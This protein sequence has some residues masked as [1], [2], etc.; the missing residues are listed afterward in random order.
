MIRVS[1]MKTVSIVKKYAGLV[2]ADEIASLE[3]EIISSLPRFFESVMPSG[4]IVT[5]ADLDWSVAKVEGGVDELRSTLYNVR[6][7]GFQDF[8]VI[9]EVADDNADGSFSVVLSAHLV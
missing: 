6:A 4:Q 3:S 7:F 8:F 2:S 9:D 5:A 1:N